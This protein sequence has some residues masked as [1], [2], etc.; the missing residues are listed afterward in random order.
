M[1]SGIKLTTIEKIQQGIVFTVAKLIQILPLMALTMIYT[2]NQSAESYMPYILFY[3]AVKTGLLLING[4]GHVQNT[5]RLMQLSL[6]MSLATLLVL[7][8]SPWEY[9][10]DVAAFLLGLSASVILPTYEGVYYHE[11]VVWKWFL[12]GVEILTLFVTSAVILTLIAIASHF[13]YRSVFA[14]ITGFVLVGL[15]TMMQF[16]PFAKQVGEPLFVPH[17]QSLR[18]LEL[19][20]WTTVMVFGLRYLRFFD[21]SFAWTIILVAAVGL[22]ALV[23]R[24]LIW[25]SKVPGLPS[26]TVVSAMLN[27]AYETFLMLYIFLAAHGQTVMISAYVAYGLGMM[28]AQI[29]R[30][31]LQR[32]FRGMS[33]LKLQLLFFGLGAWLTIW[34]NTLLLGAFVISF[35]GSANSI[36]LN[37]DVYL[38]EVSTPAH[39]LVVK[40]RSTYL[41]SILMQFVFIGGMMGL[42]VVRDANLAQIMWQINDA[43]ISPATS[44]FVRLVGM[45]T[46]LVL[47]IL[48]AWAYWRLPDIDERPLQ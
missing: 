16:K 31:P 40:Y 44:Q 37:H 5:F 4:F 20:S 42:S 36:L 6:I 9:L 17:T 34:P 19:F 27:G 18:N 2:T 22:V 46:A 12:Q 13:S 11:R 48:T 29:V 28:L 32:S 41:G 7:S 30:R 43:T 14:I 47:T 39:R 15:V 8:L 1:E 3:T 25:R 45:V 24:V 38:T 35:F 33:N 10:T 21:K 26:W 23:S